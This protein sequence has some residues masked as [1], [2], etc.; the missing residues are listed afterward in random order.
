M[1][2]FYMEVNMPILN[3]SY[4]MEKNSDMKFKIYDDSPF[5]YVLWT[6]KGDYWNMQSGAEMGLYFRNDNDP[7]YSEPDHYT[8]IGFEVPMTLS[9]YNCY[10]KDN[11]ENV[12]NWYPNTP[13][14]WI[15]GFNPSFTEPDSDIM[16]IIGTVNLCDRPAMYDGLKNYAQNEAK[17]FESLIFDDKQQIVWVL[18]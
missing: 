17:I 5:Q 6:W 2:L 14:W 13:Q 15:T 1:Q 3:E 18:W 12:F 8:A 16:Q 7:A 9:L 11:I 10:S 4:K